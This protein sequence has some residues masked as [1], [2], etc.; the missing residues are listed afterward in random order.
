MYLLW[1]NIGVGGKVIGVVNID[2][3]FIGSL[4]SCCCNLLFRT[5]G[6]HRHT[7]QCCYWS[8]KSGCRG[9]GRGV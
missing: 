2:N 1:A 3:K 8:K 7:D 6:L 4:A 9:G 5:K